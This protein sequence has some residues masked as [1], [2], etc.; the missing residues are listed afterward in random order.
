[1][2]NAAAGN[3]NR[4]GRRGAAKPPWH[5]PRVGDFVWQLGQAGGKHKEGVMSQV[6]R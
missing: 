2:R 5:L 1:M 4:E 6:G 3:K